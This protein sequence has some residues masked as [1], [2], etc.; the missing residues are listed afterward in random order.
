MDPPAP[1]SPSAPSPDPGAALAAARRALADSQQQLAEL[2]QLVVELPAIFERKFAERLQ[3]LLD[4]QRL[5]S[6]DNHAL[7]ERL[8]LVLA[9]AREAGPGGAGSP[10]ADPAQAPAGGAEPAAADQAASSPPA[11]EPASESAAARPAPGQARLAWRR[12]LHQA[13]RRLLRRGG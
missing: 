11:N 10:S 5:L 1:A 4:R 8:Q 6:E 7:R 13:T 2:E 9:P 3:P 12:H